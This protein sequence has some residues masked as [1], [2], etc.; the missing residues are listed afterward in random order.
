MGKLHGYNFTLAVTFRK[1]MEVRNG[2]LK[3]VVAFQLQPFFTS[4]I[5]G[6]RVSSWQWAETWLNC[7][8]QTT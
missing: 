8:V 2:S 7:Q 3:T 6:E 5:V 4:M 1:I